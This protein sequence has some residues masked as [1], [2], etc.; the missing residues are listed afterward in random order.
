MN[1][2]SLENF[3]GFGSPSIADPEAPQPS[4]YHD[5]DIAIFL[6]NISGQQ[7]A[8]QAHHEDHYSAEMLQPSQGIGPDLGDVPKKDVIPIV[9]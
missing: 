8:R 4:A 5:P 2:D 7:E 3:V 9:D 6:S 1:A